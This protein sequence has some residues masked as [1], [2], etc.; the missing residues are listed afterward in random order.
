MEPSLLASVLSQYDTF[1]KYAKFCQNT[2]L[3]S[4]CFADHKGAQCVQ[5]LCSHVFCHSCLGDY[6]KLCIAEGDV[7]RVGC[8]DPECV[9]AGRQAVEEE[10][11]RV[12]SMEE[13]RRWR[14]LKE[15]RIMEKGLFKSFFIRRI[16][17]LNVNQTLPSCTVLDHLAKQS[18]QSP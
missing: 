14:T 16:Q 4:I 11:A 9:K 18:L 5:L 6:W 15:K 3:C 10:V 8:P 12:A 13:I 17:I 1:A 2:F 7:E